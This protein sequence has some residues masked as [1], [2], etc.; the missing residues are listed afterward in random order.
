MERIILQ[1]P[2][3][4]CKGRDTTKTIFLERWHLKKWVYSPHV[5]PYTWSELLE[6]G[7]KVTDLSSYKSL[8]KPHF[9]CDVYWTLMSRDC[10]WLAYY[11]WFLR[12]G[13]SPFKSIGMYWLPW[14]LDP[15][16]A[17][18]PWKIMLI[19][20]WLCS[21]SL[22]LLIVC[23]LTCYVFLLTET[24]SSLGWGLSLDESVLHLIQQ[25]LDLVVASWRYCNTE[26]P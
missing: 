16:I 13:P 5:P 18:D 21:A 20:L 2:E 14:A 22:S 8:L 25:S 6:E 19:L 17:A 1:C 9:C 12:K 7:H 26:N 24:V 11:A 23:L 15:W 10:Y 3:T 4:L